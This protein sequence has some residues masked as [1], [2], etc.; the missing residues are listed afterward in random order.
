MMQKVTHAWA[1]IAGTMHGSA[2]YLL[3]QFAQH[4]TNG[5]FSALGLH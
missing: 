5:L 4:M 2:Q 3:E 1:E